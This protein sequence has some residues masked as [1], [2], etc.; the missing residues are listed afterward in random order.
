MPNFALA[1]LFATLAAAPESVTTLERAHPIEREL[2]GG[3]AHSYA[4]LLSAGDFL[5]VVFD[6]RGID[7][8]VTAYGPDQKKFAEVD[9]PNGDRG[10]EPVEFVTP[11]AGTYR[12]DV[13]SLEK[14][15]KP[16][17]YE[18]RIEQWLTGEEYAAHLAAI[19]A[20]DVAASS[21]IRRI[22]MPLRATEAG[23]GFADLEP[24][25]ALV[26]D[27]HLVALG[28]ATHGARDFFQLKHRLLEFL[29][30]RKGFTVFAIEATMPEAF[31]VNEYVLS[32]KGDARKAL[33]GL[34]F[35]TWNTEEV[36]DMIE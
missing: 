34:Y 6:Q 2:T 30:E 7:V 14:N 26:G 15:A 11:V 22:A 24:L 10:P 5:R 29:V 25:G 16:G 18:A 17:R 27:A 4:L 21:E 35:W 3:D 20:A 19:R 36:L 23:N 33:A 12:F 28:E 1:L 9:S 31:D 8:V 13:R 32:G